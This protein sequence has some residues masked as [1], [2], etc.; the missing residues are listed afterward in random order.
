MNTP[1]IRGPA[2]ICQK[3]SAVQSLIRNFV[4][5]F[6]VFPDDLPVEARREYE[7]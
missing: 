2:T 7:T 5:F 1:S 3:L 6:E 4:G